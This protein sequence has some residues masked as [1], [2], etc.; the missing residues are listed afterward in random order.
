VARVY[1]AGPMT[2]RP[3]FNADAF[4]RAKGMLH[5][6]GHEPVSPIDLNLAS[7]L[8]SVAH[9]GTVSEAVEYSRNAAL[10][11]DIRALVQCDAIA[12]LSGWQESKGA[13]LEERIARALGL[14]RFHVDIASGQ[15][16]PALLVGLS[17]YARSGKNT[18]CA[19]LV[20]HAGFV[21]LAFADAVR[22]ALVAINPLV[23]YGDELVRTS[24]VVATG[25]WEIAKAGD[26]V[27]SLLQ[28][29]G[30]E[31]GRQVHGEDAWVDVAMRAADHR[32]VFSD[33]R[34]PNEADTIRSLGGIVIRINRP[35]VEPTNGHPSE[36]ALDNYEFDFV[37][38]NTGTTR[39]LQA[40]VVR[41]VNSWIERNAASLAA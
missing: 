15:V 22:T 30:T 35:G 1:I 12:L 19:G 25:G 41:I 36:T 28:R 10:S 21:R 31:G 29:V 39:Q 4:I 33:V 17:G 5:L 37:V 7:G 24:T 26:E 38:S 27:R 8:I 16:R 2:G 34:F 11:G 18:A 20:E 32:T 23:P 6:L 9:D 3:N 14:R 40:A 13:S